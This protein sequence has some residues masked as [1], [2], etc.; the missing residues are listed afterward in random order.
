MYFSHKLVIELAKGS[1][2]LWEAEEDY[3]GTTVNSM[4][5]TNS[6]I[7]NWSALAKNDPDAAQWTLVSVLPQSVAFA[8]VK[9]EANT[10]SNG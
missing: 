3:H 10:R 5:L 1:L 7:E 9:A 2:W 6:N 4:A 8:A